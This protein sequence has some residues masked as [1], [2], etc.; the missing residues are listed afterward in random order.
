MVGMFMNIS[1]G[2]L[3]LRNIAEM[4]EN[5]RYRRGCLVFFCGFNIDRVC[6]IQ[7][8]RKQ[9]VS[10]SGSFLTALLPS[11]SE[12]FLQKFRKGRLTPVS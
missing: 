3:S 12:D 11:I 9:T 1:N 5:H 7:K 2:Y 8:K 10:K 6:M 4:V